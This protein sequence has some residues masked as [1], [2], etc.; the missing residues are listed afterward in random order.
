DAV[1]HDPLLQVKHPYLNQPFFIGR[2]ILYFVI[3]LGLGHLFFKGSVSQ[4]KDGN[5]SHTSKLQG[6]AAIAVLLYAFSQSFAAIDWMMSLTPHWYST[7]YGVYFFAGSAVASLSAISL[8]ALI[9]RKGG[10]LKSLITK[11]HYHDLG[12]LLFGFNIFWV[13]IG[14][15]QYFLIWY[16][17]IPEETIFF[18]DRISTGW[19]PITILL[20]VGHFF[21]PL[22]LFMSRHAKRHLGVHAFMVCWMLAIHFIDITWLIKPTHSLD[23]FHFGITDFAAFLT[24]G[25]LFVGLLFTNLKKFSLY[26][27]KDPRLKE[28]M[29]FENV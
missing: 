19:R 12:K 6:L 22:F 28:S 9:L 23:G 18:I 11:E 8:V 1:L 3:W 21:V 16:A 2:Y 17:N 14:F 7:I 13:Y 20:V 24:I 25:G 10:F 27:C 26:P 29:E 4:D 5:P 15:S